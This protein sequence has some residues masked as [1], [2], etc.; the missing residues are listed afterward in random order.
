M[1]DGTP[2]ALNLYAGIGGNRKLWDGVDTTAVEINPKIAQF[3]Q[4]EFPDDEVIVADAHGFLEDH[5]DDGWD[6]IWSSPPCQTHSKVS[7]MTWASDAPQNAPRQPEYPDM[8][9]YQEV[10]FLRTFAEC[11][12]VVENVQPYYDPLITPQTIDRHSFWSNIRLPSI[13]VDTAA[14]AWTNP[15][16][17]EYME[18]YGFDVSDVDL[19]HR[20]DQVLRNCV[21]PKI[22]RHILDTA[23]SGDALE[24]ATIDEVT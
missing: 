14:N 2:K 10:I 18:H 11:D 13:E 21:D 20:K 17:E 24:Q 7:R 16:Q 3:Y 4:S 15:S 8:R 1:T 23:L 9:L 19:G 12:W 6:F 22:G 5:Y